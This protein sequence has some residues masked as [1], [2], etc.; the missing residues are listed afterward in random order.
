MHI[1]YKYPIS[2]AST[3]RKLIKNLNIASEISIPLTMHLSLAPMNEW[4][5]EINYLIS[6][7]YRDSIS[8]CDGEGIKNISK[9]T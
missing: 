6:K 5:W 4:E 2:T 1:R 9:I 3:L 8:F 7:G